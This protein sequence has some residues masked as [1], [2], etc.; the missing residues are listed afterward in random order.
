MG[1]GLLLIGLM[2]LAFFSTP[3]FG[4][5]VEAE[6][7]EN[8]TGARE[9]VGGSEQGFETVAPIIPPPDAILKPVT[10]DDPFAGCRRRS[11]GAG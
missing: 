1:F 11:S 9:L 8:D 7:P 4:G 3:W 10:D 2:P 5:E 6:E